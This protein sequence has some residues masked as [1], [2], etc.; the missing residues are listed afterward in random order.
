MRRLTNL[1]AFLIVGLVL[2]G[3]ATTSTPDTL[4]EALNDPELSNLKAALE[5]EGLIAALESQTNVTIFAPVD[6]AFGLRAQQVSQADIL[7]YHAIPGVAAMSTDLV[8]G[9]L[10]SPLFA[11]ST[12][13]VGVDGSAVT[14][15]DGS[16][17]TITVT[18]ANI[19]IANGVIHKIDTVLTPPD[20]I[21]AVAAAGN[22]TILL[23]ALTTLDLAGSFDGNDDG[24]NTVFAPTDAAFAALLDELN[25]TTGLA[26]LVAALGEDTVTQILLH[27]V[28]PGVVD[29]SEAIA[30]ATSGTPVDT[31][32]PGNP[33]SLSLNGANVEI[34]S[35][36]GVGP[37]TITATNLPT[38][39]GTI[40]VV[41]QVIVFDLN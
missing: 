24:P 11:N 19:E 3:C 33:L 27:H 40:H 31:L 30:A 1:V 4:S 21:A 41:D 39:N 7:S 35:P 8:D 9:Q 29:R 26:G 23:D 18:E 32:S 12:L 37:A 15:N 17:A 20:T 14:L 5:A 2:A 6:S 36:S 10:L 13:G 25:I 22:F 16:G 34:A 28:V 38:S